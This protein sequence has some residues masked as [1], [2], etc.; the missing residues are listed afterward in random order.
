MSPLPT[1]VHNPLSW[2]VDTTRPIRY[3]NT[4]SR[5]ILIHWAQSSQYFAPRQPNTF[6]RAIPYLKT[7]NRTKPYPNTLIPNITT[8]PN[9][10]LSEYIAELLPILLHSSWTLSRRQSLWHIIKYGK[11][12]NPSHSCATQSLS[13]IVARYSCVKREH[14][15]FL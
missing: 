9:Y 12:P 1:F 7:I 5:T 8:I 3:P 4:M 6:P 2:Y 14:L 15:F 13:T 11:L 10:T